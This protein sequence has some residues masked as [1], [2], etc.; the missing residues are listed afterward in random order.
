M[1]PQMKIRW[2]QIISNFKFEIGHHLCAS[3]C[4]CGVF[5]LIGAGPGLDSLS[6]DS[7]RVELASDG[8]TSLLQRSYVA[9]HVPPD[10]RGPEQAVMA[11][12]ELSEL[13]PGSPNNAA[14]LRHV[15]TGISQALPQINDPNVLL[16]A[17]AMLVKQAVEQDVN[18]L[19]Y[20][21]EDGAETTKA[22]LAPAVNTAIALYQRA[23]DLLN[24]TQ[25]DLQNKITSPDDPIVKQ[26]QSVYQQWQT[27][28]YT[29]WML[30]YSQALAMDRNAHDRPA[31]V[32]AAI[33]NLAQ[34]DTP[35]S[36][37]QP[38]VMLQ[39][40][41]LYMLL[42][43]SLD[44]KKAEDLFSKLALATTDGS[45][46]T[47]RPDRFTQFNALYFRAVCYVLAANADAADAAG[48][49]ADDYRVHFVPG[50]AG[51][52]YAMD[53]LHYRIALLRKDNATAVNILENLD[54]KAP[55]LRPLIARQLLDKMPA[56]PDPTQLSPLMLSAVIARAWTQTSAASP[57]RQILEDGLAAATQYLARA[58]LA[59]PQTTPDGT[60]DA[61]KARG[62]I[63]KTLGRHQEA[64]AAFLDHA[65]RFLHDP[66]AQSAE[67]LNEAIEQ[68]SILYQTQNAAGL[69]A[70][71][72]QSDVTALED[73]LLP[74]AVDSFRRY[75]L[76]YEYARRLQRAGHASMAA[77]EFELV[78]NDDP[79]ALN[80]K[81]FLLAALD[82]RLEAPPTD[83]PDAVSAAELPAVLQQV[84]EVADL[85]IAQAQ[86]RNARSLRVRAVLLAAQ[87]EVGRGRDPRQ[88]I[89]RLEGF[90]QLAAGLPD[91]K[92]LI[93]D[94]LNLRVAAFMGEGNID[95]ATGTLLQYLSSTGGDEGLQTVYNLLTR[96]NREMDRAEADDDTQR[97]RE[98]ADDRAALTPFLVRWAESNPNP[99]IH[100]FTYRYRVFDAAT[101]KQAAELEPEAA[102]RAQKLNDALA[103]YQ[104]LQS[105]DNLK[106]YQAS[107]GPDAG[108]D[109]INYPD[110]AVILG[111]GDT[112]FAL[113]NWKLAHDSIGQ[114]LADSKLGD[115]TMV[116]KNAAGQEET[117]DNEQFWQAQYEFIYATALMARDTSSG[118]SSQTPKIIL[119]RLQAIWQDRIGGAKW[120]EKFQELGEI[121]AAL[122]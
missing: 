21:G 107:L 111:I 17:A 87:A 101:R 109:V 5:L 52:D 86:Q 12:R 20:F 37:V 99:D 80:A 97:V 104:E 7:L 35:D 33:D 105:P 102:Q 44:L 106:L 85:A 73:R 13:P 29:R 67:A 98:L 84:E 10:Q 39:R 91:R 53:M 8:L 43:D 23:I 34:W 118:V 47:P 115:G 48:R 77:A 22:R 30:T 93:S 110:P 28:A 95:A 56:H 46:I 27:A 66:N 90:E 61:S 31:I 60:I 2:T 117:V 40:A 69:D 19:E 51:D 120:H 42:G 72:H 116:V 70:Q 88:A 94:A 9:D 59:D 18:V 100:K 1:S 62:V 15:V 50:V 63:L 122:Q 68:I 4:I 14:L 92:E 96:L 81:L 121:V 82:R 54:Q 55:G 71:G 75:D 112:A 49:A 108:A 36:G 32:Q 58:D 11:L 65:Q 38:I 119:S 78:P 45:A 25:T 83:T 64:A 24:A 26:W 3:V 114:L 113:G 89:S 57:D 76:A 16:S 6:D 79:N 103:R 41:K 74:L